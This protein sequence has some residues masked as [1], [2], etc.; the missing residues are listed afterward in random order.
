MLH[1]GRWAIELYH[2]KCLGR[3]VVSA[4]HARKR[5]GSLPTGELPSMPRKKYWSKWKWELI[6]L[7]LDFPRVLKLCVSSPS[8]PYFVS[9]ERS[10]LLLFYSLCRSRIFWC[11]EFS[12][13]LQGCFL[14][15][16]LEIFWSRQSVGLGDCIP[17]NHLNA[18]WTTIFLCPHNRMQLLGEAAVIK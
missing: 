12:A 6:V 17:L 1:W 10:L 14:G 11:I 5:D 16:C 15:P 3:F 18:A 13:V 4:I 9:C 8:S 2:D 7:E